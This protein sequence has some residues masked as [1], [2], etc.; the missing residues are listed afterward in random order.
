MVLKYLS[1]LYN[2][3]G[4]T[5]LEILSVGGYYFYP[6]PPCAHVWPICKCEFK[7]DN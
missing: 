4:Y 7:E 2:L 3:E 1:V 6:F 5:Q